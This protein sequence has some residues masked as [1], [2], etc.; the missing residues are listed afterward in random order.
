MEIPPRDAG[1]PA[2]IRSA[3]QPV[4]PIMNHARA[5]ALIEQL[6]FRVAK[7]MPRIPHEYTVRDKD[8][9]ARETAYVQ[10]FHLIQTDG[11]IERW[12]GR[13]TR[14]LDPGDGW[15]YWAM[16]TIEA[17]SRMMN[18]MRVEDDIERLRRRGQKSD[19]AFVVT[20]VLSLIP[21]TFGL[22]AL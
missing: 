1:R 8:D 17:E 12:Q 19:G 16:T 4:D 7:S 22:T 15:K 6:L 14:F 13:K 21:N 9:L 11:E 2:I 10:L 20:A 18:R 5:L 3:T